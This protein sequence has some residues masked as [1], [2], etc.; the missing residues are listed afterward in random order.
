MA[1]FHDHIK[2]QLHS[3][4]VAALKEFGVEIPEA[5]GVKLAGH[6]SLPPQREMGHLCFPCFPLAKT[7]RKSP[8]QISQQL[9]RTLAPKIAAQDFIREINPTGPYLN[10]WLRMEVVAPSLLGKIES[11]DFFRGPFKERLPKTMIEYFQPNTHK[12]VHVGHLR[13]LCM[14]LAMV[15][16]HRYL[17]YPMISATY[18]G[19]SGTHVAKVLWYLQ[20]EN[21]TPPEGRDLGEWLG[22]IYALANQALSESPEKGQELASILKAMGEQSGAS[23]ELW[24]QTRQWSLEHIRKICSWADVEFDHW[25]FESEV[26]IPSLNFARK[27]YE[28][29]KLVKDDG[30]IIMDLTEEKLPPCLLIK[31]DGNGLYATKDL[32]LARKKFE[33]YGIEKSIYVVDKRQSLHFKQVFKTLEKIGYEQ[34]KNCYHLE[35]EFVEL[36]DGAISSRKGNIISAQSFIDKMQRTIRENFLTRYK[37]WS[38]EEKRRVADQVAQGAIKYGMTSVDSN[39]KI[40][41]D[42]KNW[43]QLDGES[44]PYIQYA[45]A[46]IQ[47]LLGKVSLGGDLAQW[48]WSQLQHPLEQALVVELAQF[49]NVVESACDHYKTSTLTSYLYDLAKL[50]N[51]FY[52][53]CPILKA[54]GEN[55]KQVRAHL[56]HKTGLVLAQGLGLLGIPSPDK[57]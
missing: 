16:C 49:N 28:Q 2:K 31:R 9:A 48:D 41:F 21:P 4:L 14:G 6:W 1:I 8:A 32:E 34:A 3:S 15:K 53:Q 17:G 43:L 36:P 12:E 5:E 40:V 35:Y 19:D 27:L 39:K 46:R 50:F 42:M 56:A 22:T 51:S 26:D 37:D 55:L 7:L 25:Y 57:M 30:A 18:P 24:Q 47:S 29:G 23:F 44:G 38:V 11:G 20:K 52:A 13:N 33:D 54:D 45:H 10:F